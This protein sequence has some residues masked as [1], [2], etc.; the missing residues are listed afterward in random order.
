MRCVSFCTAESY[1]LPQIA[2]FLKSQ[3][4]NVK[5]YRKLLH[6][7]HPYQTGDIFVFTFGCLVLWGLKRKT[8]AELLE[9]IKPYAVNPLTT[10][11]H[12]RFVARYGDNTEIITH[13]TFNAD[14]IT[15]ESDNAQIKLAISFGLAQSIQLESYESAIQKTIDENAYL[16]Q[17]LAQQGTIP[18]SQKKISKRLGKIFLARSSINLNSDYL[19]DPEYFWE[20]PSIETYYTMSKRFLDIPRRVS[21]L[22][23][24]LNI[25]HELFEILTSQRQHRHSNILEVTIILLIAIEIMLTLL[26]KVAGW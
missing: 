17:Q 22:N 21:A 1:K 24:K 16:P 5:Q 11:E 3:G 14:I 25:L 12:D 19:E 9:L 23:Q 20:H 2:T 15:L 7:N 10:I 4:Y 13:D 6:I 26:F 18:L 8:E